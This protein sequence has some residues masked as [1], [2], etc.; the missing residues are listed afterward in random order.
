MHSGML[1]SSSCWAFSATE[2]IESMWIL[3]GHGTNSTVDLAPQQIVD[4]D[5]GRG[6]EGC[7]GGDT[8]TAYEYGNKTKYCKNLLFVQ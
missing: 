8:V 2:N 5:V 3:A 7:E 4:C 1:T 6:D